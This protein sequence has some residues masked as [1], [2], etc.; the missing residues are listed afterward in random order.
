MGRSGVI[1]TVPAGRPTTSSTAGAGRKKE[2]VDHMTLVASG[3]PTASRS[4][5]PAYPYRSQS[6]FDL[7]RTSMVA[8]TL[9]V[10]APSLIS[11]ISRSAVSQRRNGVVGD[12]MT[13]GV[14][15]PAAMGDGVPTRAL[16]GAP[17]EEHAVNKAAANATDRRLASLMNC[18]GVV[19]PSV[20]RYLD[21][22]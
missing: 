15:V 22:S 5:I 10:A 13:K 20:T 14:G 6:R 16:A 2:L 7:F 8:P 17:P 1:G 19:P 18:H 4:C 3:R 21:S 9:P 12:G 11:C